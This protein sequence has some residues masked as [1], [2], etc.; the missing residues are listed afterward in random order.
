MNILLLLAALFVLTPLAM[1]W[2]GFA[3]S[4]IWGW[5][6]VP[7]FPMMPVLSIPAAI[8]LTLVIGY[9]TGRVTKKDTEEDWPFIIAKM[10][11]LPAFAIGMSY[12]IKQFM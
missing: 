7:T 5:L 11:L 8:G 12:I 3:L 1:I 10:V 4:V 2:S 6:I 9:L